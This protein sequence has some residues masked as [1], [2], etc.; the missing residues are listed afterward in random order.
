MYTESFKVNV[1]SIGKI[2][3]EAFTM[4]GVTVASKIRPKDARR[5]VIDDT[6]MTDFVRKT[7]GREL[8]VEANHNYYSQ[9]GS[10]LGF[11]HN[12]TAIDQDLR[13]DIRFLKSAD[14]S[15]LQPGMVS[16]I[17]DSVAEDPKSYML[18][19]KVTVEYFYS[20]DNR[21]LT[22][23]YDWEQDQYVW[24]YADNKKTYAGD[25]HMKLNDVQGVDFVNEGGLTNST[26]AVG[27]EDFI[28]QFNELCAQPQVAQAIKANFHQLN[29][30]SLMTPT[31]N[32]FFTFFKKIFSMNTTTAPEGTPQDT[33][34]AAVVEASTADNATIENAVQ[35]AMSKF[36]AEIDSLK[37][38]LTA[39]D[40]EPK[41]K[42]QESFAGE[43][44]GAPIPETNSKKVPL[45]LENPI[46]S[47]LKEKFLAEN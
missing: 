14:A 32:N 46:N 45:Y 35:A 18:S 12:F 1:S 15:P 41:T 23:A 11:I 31:D 20:A 7:K 36:Q 17:L 3:R 39:K 25:V 6:F 44:F 16:F 43:N 37:V 29:I 19:M 4:S 21:T 47:K 2:D 40:Q 42:D 8:P 30:A 22:R 13:A 26:F 38:Q 9:V 34:P 27:D 33:P 10:K 5:I 28:H 24:K